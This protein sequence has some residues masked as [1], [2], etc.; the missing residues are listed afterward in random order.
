MES[1]RV[2]FTGDVTISDNTADIG[3]G[4]CQS[5]GYLGITTVGNNPSQTI[6]IVDNTANVAPTG[7]NLNSGDGG[8]GGIIVKGGETYFTGTETNRIQILRNKAPNGNGGGIYFFR[9]KP[10][11]TYCNIGSSGNGN[12]AAKRGGGI[13]LGNNQNAFYARF[14]NCNIEYN[15]TTSNDVDSKG[16]GVF[17]YGTLSNNS[18]NTFTKCNIRYNGENGTYKTKKGGGLYLQGSTELDSC[19]IR[20]WRHSSGW[21]KNQKLF[22]Y[23]KFSK[24][25]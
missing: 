24:P 12:Y 2:V 13:Y 21:A 6:K 16:G 1:G 19:T 11:F 17:N 5:E 25:F 9:G 18:T 20:G 23:A 10:R 8:G 3:G 7:S 4:I 22:F 15:Y 14:T